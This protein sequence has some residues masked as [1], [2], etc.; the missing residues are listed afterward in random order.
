MTATKLSDLLPIPDGVEDP[1]AYQVFGLEGGE[2]DA[3][4]IKSAVQQV[5][6]QLKSAKSEADP[7]VWKKA[8]KIAERSKALLADPA[9]RAELDARFGVVATASSPTTAAGIAP[10]GVPPTGMPPTGAPPAGMP[11]GAAAPAPADPLAG[12][13][14]NVNPLAAPAPSTVPAQPT[15]PPMTPSPPGTAPAM[16]PSQAIPSQAAPYQMPPGHAGVQQY[17]QPLTAQNAPA[18]PAPAQASSRPT[19]APVF[20]VKKSKKRRRSSLGK[21]LF[22]FAACFL[23]IAIAGLAAFKAFGP[24]VAVTKDGVLI[25]KLPPKEKK[26]TTSA[27]RKERYPKPKRNV[28]PVMGSMSGGVDPPAKLSSTG[29]PVNEFSPPQ[30]DNASAADNASDNTGMQEPPSMDPASMDPTSTDSGMLPDLTGDMTTGDMTTEDAVPDVNAADMADSSPSD[31]AMTPSPSTPVPEVN[32]DGALPVSPGTET[33]PVKLTD[34]QIAAN[35]AAIKQV[36]E[37]IAGAKWIEM[38][39]A[40]EK[41]TEMML[42]D[43]QRVEADALYNLADLAMFYR[44]AVQRGLGTLKATQDFEV[45]EGF[46]VLVVEV[47]HSSLTVRYNARNKTYSLDEIPFRLAEKISTFAL[48]PGKPD[49]IAAKS[50]YQAISPL[51]NDEHRKEAINWLELVNDDLEDVDTKAVG[52]M[53]QSIF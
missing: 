10:A 46:R 44:G 7:K 40:A 24:G 1:H 30:S 25:G 13:L 28:D 5:Y 8:A 35:D 23:G 17:G 34:Q 39:P 42:S 33:G 20:K 52:E 41:L 36:K 53:I 11:P 21:T 27:P 45:A 15:A 51:S 2:Q 3:G 50:C 32:P 49:S 18:P 9:Q 22:I 31:P 47:S 14:P 38:K 12:M 4:K 48:D 26:P 43:E 16:P 29:I 6:A 37:L 19:A